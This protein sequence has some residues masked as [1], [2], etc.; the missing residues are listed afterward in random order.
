VNARDVVRRLEAYGQG[1]PLV[2]GTTLRLRVADDDDLL[3]LAFVR[4]GGE[5]LPW[6]T[7]L[8]APGTEAEVFAIPDAR[9][10]DR[11]GEML[12][13][14]TPRLGDFLE[15]PQWSHGTFSSDDPADAVPFKQLWVPNG[16]HVQML[17]MLNL[18]YT[19]ARAGDPA[20]AATLRALGRLAGFLFRE[21]ARPGEAT[22]V[23][24]SAALRDAFTFPADDLRQQHL[25]LLLALLGT[26]RNGAERSE[27]AERAERLSVSTSLAPEVERDELEPL[28]DRHTGA[29]RDGDT[30]A[31]HKAER[32]IAEALDGEVRRRLDLSLKT[33]A[34][35]RADPRPVNVGALELALRSTQAR[36]RD[37]LWLEER[38]IENG[39]EGGF[40]PP[41]PETDRNRKTGA[42]RYH[43]LSSADQEVA[44]TLIHDD[45]ELQQDALAAGDAV[46]GTIIQ[47]HDRAPAG[48]RGT[49]PVWI[50]EAASAAPSRLRRG[51]GVCVAGM[52]KR[53]GTVLNV[54]TAGDVR[55]LEIQIDNWKR[56]PDPARY[57]QFAHALP[58]A[59]A[60]LEGE[61]VL[62]LSSTLAGL[63]VRKSSRVRGDSGPGGWLTHGVGN[64]PVKGRL[65]GRRG[66]VLAEVDGLRRG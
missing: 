36:Q 9:D 21:A 11:V 33:A 56:K 31:A 57:P 35:L 51:S 22:I 44:A 49:L 14:I 26:Y 5:S 18:R 12:L 6:A 47:V 7:G 8:S 45:L 52:P 24:A 55:Q 66:N 39:E 50:V 62:L 54:A 43:R 63:G 53:T 37:F 16:S 13:Q 40:F 64:V 1:I 4:M 15:H 48:S 46:R 2:R 10:R 28:V 42:A 61:D 20:R 23:D 27:A 59:D 34:L 19:F 60:A 30:Q 41:S 38:L 58:A 29:R 65:R 3:A 25:G 32:G 17:H